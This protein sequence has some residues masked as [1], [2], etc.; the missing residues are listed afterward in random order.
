M[1]PRERR[2][3]GVRGT[4]SPGLSGPVPTKPKARRPALPRVPLPR[5]MGGVHENKRKRPA[6]KLKHKKKPL[7]DD[8]SSR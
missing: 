3:K 7:A 5:Q 6:R 1:G 4:T 2:R 8:D